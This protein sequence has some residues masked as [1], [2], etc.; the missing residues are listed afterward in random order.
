MV[1]TRD[2]QTPTIFVCPMHD[3][4]HAFYFTLT[5]DESM[6][7]FN[8]GTISSTLHSIITKKK[9]ENNNN[10]IM[11]LRN[12]PLIIH[13]NPAEI[14]EKAAVATLVGPRK[15]RGVCYRLARSST[16]RPAFNVVTK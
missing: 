13:Q 2:G 16:I 11:G 15:L 12:M 10:K 9:P 7:C 14:G 3:H 6:Q 5:M 4:V 1:F 8:Y